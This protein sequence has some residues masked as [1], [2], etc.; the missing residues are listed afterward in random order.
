MGRFPAFSPGNSRFFRGEFMSAALR[1][2]SLS[3]FACDF[4]ALLGVHRSEAAFA[5]TSHGATP[6]VAYSCVCV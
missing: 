6:L 2:G 5:L 3:T 4:A 1:V